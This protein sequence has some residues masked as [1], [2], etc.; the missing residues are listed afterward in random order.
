MG[1]AASAAASTPGWL[2]TRCLSSNI[3]ARCISSAFL[4]ASVVMFSTATFRA[5]KPGFT[6]TNLPRLNRNAAP[7]TTRQKAQAT[8]IVTK[9]RPSRSFPACPVELRNEIIGGAPEACQAGINPKRTAENA[10]TPTQNSST[11]VSM[12]GRI[13]PDCSRLKAV[14]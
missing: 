9:I 1:H 11:R 2:S 13:P 4:P 6:R 12:V 5:S 7:V 3:K 14:S 10:E 8:W